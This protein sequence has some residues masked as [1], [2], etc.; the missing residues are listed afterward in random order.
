M[1]AADGGGYEYD[2][3]VL[4]A[5]SRQALVT[6][7]SLTRAGLR[8][9]VGECFAECDPALPVLAF[10]SRY[11]AHN[12]VVPSFAIDPTGFAAEIL[13]FVRAH[14]TRLVVPGSDGSVAAIL[15]WRE[16]FAALNCHLALPAD[17]VLDIANNKDRTL[18]IA[19]GLGIESP[20]GEQVSS[21]DELMHVLG[22]FEFPIVLKPTSSW[23]GQSGCRLQ[24]AEVIDEAEAIEVTQRFLTAG[25]GV[26]A[27]QYVGGRREGVILFVVDG[28]IH[29][30][31]AYVPHRTSPALGGASVLR[32][33]V[34]MPDDTYAAAVQLV[35]AIGMQGLC[36]V[37]F[38]RDLHGRPFLMEINARL[39]GG[40]METAMRTGID[41]PLLLWQ[42]ATGLPV[43][44]AGGYA[45][46]MRMRWLRGDM[47]WL[48]TNSRRVGRPDSMPRAKAFLAFATE[49]IRTRHYDCLDV[50]DLGPM[51]A[52]WR[53]AV[54]SVR[55]ELW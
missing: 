22:E 29:A 15:P 1:R 24:V 19:H 34:A 25:V 37:E 26:L 31:F 33:S 40:G 16:K 2:A 48:I 4:D 18:E 7:R 51:M 44:R 49:F 12:L 38:R 35:T 23:A 20:R 42:W 28:Q 46:G 13:E 55:K 6:L 21:I 39:V 17:A 47:R 43:D 54:A 32:E 50:R 3:L 11:S 53:T 41:F 8:V 5:G 27:Q 52:E 30:S 36:E 14:P 10:Q 9:A 45:A